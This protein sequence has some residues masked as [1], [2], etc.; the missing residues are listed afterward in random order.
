M[1]SNMYFML[2]WRGVCVYVSVCACVPVSTH[3]CVNAC[4]D[5]GGCQNSCCI[6]L[7]PYSFEKQSFTEPRSS[8]KPASPHNLPLSTAQELSSQAPAHPAWIFM[9]TLGSKSGLHAFAENTFPTEP[10][11]HPS[12]WFFFFFA[13]CFQPF[14]G[15]LLR[16]LT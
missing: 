6:A 7:L 13:H 15:C 5:Q 16:P 3:L 9:L 1:A 12:S 10:F 2:F 8:P 4:G 14:L 11:P